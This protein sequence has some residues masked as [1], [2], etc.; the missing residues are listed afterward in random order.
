MSNMAGC[1][2]P[3]PGHSSSRRLMARRSVSACTRQV[4]AS[5]SAAPPGDRRRATKGRWQASARD[6]Q[7]GVGGTAHVA[8]R[9]AWPRYQPRP[10]AAAVIDIGVADAGHQREQGVDAG[11][12]HAASRRDGRAQR[13][14]ADLEYGRQAERAFLA[15][16]AGAVRGGHALAVRCCD[17]PAWLCWPVRAPVQ[18]QQGAQRLRCRRDALGLRRAR[19]GAQQAKAEDGAAVGVDAAGGREHARSASMPSAFRRA[20]RRT[21]APAG[22]CAGSSGAAR[23]CCGMKVVASMSVW[24]PLSTSDTSPGF[25]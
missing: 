7:S 13:R 18:Q 10:R 25:G 6:S 8:K 16:A 19:R 20:N 23:T 2:P 12:V 17:S 9:R 5:R 4:A 24:L 21:V 11:Q 15:R 14:Q 1:W 22:K 3:W